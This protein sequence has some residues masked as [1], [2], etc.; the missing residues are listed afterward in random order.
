MKPYRRR[1]TV[2]KRAAAIASRGL[3]EALK[4]QEAA[5]RSQALETR[6]AE[7]TRKSFI[8]SLQDQVSAIGKTRTQLLELKAVK[9]G[10][11]AE[12]APLIAKLREQD[13]QWKVGTISARQYRQALRMLPAQFTDIFTS[14]AGWMPLWLVLFQQGGQ[15][16]DSFGGLDGIFRYIK[17][18]LL[19]MKGA[20]D[21]S[22]D[23]LSESANS[24]ADNAQN[25]RG[26]AS[27]LPPARLGM[28]GLAG[29]GA[30]VAYH[31]YKASDRAEQLRKSLAM[32]NSFSGLTARSLSNTIAAPV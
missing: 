26:L 19:G 1:E 30:L 31:F 13:N 21:E 20:T 3:K 15:I 23:S 7:S 22:N 14:I 9:L 25:A 16:S 27:I 11:T 4:E 17:E 18:E 8:D 28:I 2:Q 5:E 6:R 32:T 29:A 10:V 24:L 12:S